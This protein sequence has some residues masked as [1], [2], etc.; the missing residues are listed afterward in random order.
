MDRARPQSR[1]KTL[2]VEI[3]APEYDGKNSVVVRQG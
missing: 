1:G 2:G 3:L